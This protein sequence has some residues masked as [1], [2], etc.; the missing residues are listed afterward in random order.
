MLPTNPYLLFLLDG[1][2]AFLSAFFLGFVLVHFQSYI[3][4]PREVLQVLA[5]VPVFYFIFSFWNFWRKPKKWQ[6]L[7][8]GIAMANLIYCCLTF[9]LLIAFFDGLT[10]IGIG[11]F[12]FEIII[13]VALSAYELKI[14]TKG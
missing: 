10:T 14:A 4:L 6:P 9:G 3:G 11:Y 5:G 7:L 2:G 12:V 1:V 8:K 13:I